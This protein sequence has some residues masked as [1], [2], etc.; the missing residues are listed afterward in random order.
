MRIILQPFLTI[1]AASAVV[2]LSE[3]A[4][5]RGCHNSVIPHIR[6]NGRIYVD[7]VALLDALDTDNGGKPYRKE[8]THER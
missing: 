6:R 3:S 2:N 5:R 8:M 4:L 7:M 1:R